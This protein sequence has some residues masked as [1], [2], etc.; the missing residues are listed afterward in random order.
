[1]EA[2][3]A[4]RLPLYRSFADVS[5]KNDAPPEQVAARIWEAVYEVLGD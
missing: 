3:Y 4:K 1:L 2:L 5:V